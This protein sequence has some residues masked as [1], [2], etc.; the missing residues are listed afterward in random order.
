MYKVVHVTCTEKHS[1][2]ACLHPK[3][4]IIDDNATE[5]ARGKDIGL[6]N[7]LANAANKGLA[8]IDKE[9]RAF[10]EGQMDDT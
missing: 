6:L 7:A 8:T 4:A 1:S 2:P 5:I 10:I 3:L 9:V